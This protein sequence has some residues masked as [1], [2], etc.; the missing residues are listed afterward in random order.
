MKIIKIIEKNLS[1][2]SWRT[3]GYDWDYDF[4]IKPSQ[5]KIK[6]LYGLHTKIFNNITPSEKEPYNTVI[7]DNGSSIFATCFLTDSQFDEFDRPIK[8]Y[9]MYATN[10][11]EEI[12]TIQKN[13]KNEKSWGKELLKLECIENK[14]VYKKELPPPNNS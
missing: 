11:P 5:N 14:Y 8:H 1:N 7:I 6:N 12:Q 13:I 4:L 2:L 9:F 3:R 10:S